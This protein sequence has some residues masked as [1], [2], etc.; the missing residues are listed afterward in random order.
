MQ[1]DLGIIN[2]IGIFTDTT[3]NNNNNDDD[4]SQ[5]ITINGNKL[6]EMYG[7]NN[8][9]I[10]MMKLSNQLNIS[11][12]IENE[13]LL[14]NLSSILYPI[15]ENPILPT[16]FESNIV[17]NGNGGGGGIYISANCIFPLIMNV[18]FIDNIIL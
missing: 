9:H 2:Y 10:T 17:T 14:Y 15:I 4:E 18:L 8:Y 6:N 3:I 13:L 7:Y 5:Y 16:I 11:T 1:I 12:T